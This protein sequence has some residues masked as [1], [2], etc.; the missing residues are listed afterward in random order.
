MTSFIARQ[1]GD[2]QAQE[3]VNRYAGSQDAETNENDR[4]QTRPCQHNGRIYNQKTT[5]TRAAVWF[6]QKAKKSL[7][8]PCVM[9]SR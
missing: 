5:L 9:N 7:E 6:A 2:F 1:Q 8:A 3:S 4:E